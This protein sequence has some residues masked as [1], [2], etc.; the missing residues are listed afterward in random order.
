MEEVSSAAYSGADAAADEREAAAPEQAEAA[1]SYPAES[2]QEDRPAQDLPAQGVPDGLPDMDMLRSERARLEAEQERTSAERSRLVAEEQVRQIG[3]LD[4]EIKSLD[5]LLDMPEYGS[6]YELV[7]KGVSLV[8]AYKL[9]RYDKLMKRAAD[10]AARQTVRSIGSRRHLTALAGQ[11]GTGEY[12]SV[13]AEVAAEYRLAKPGI[14]DEEIR[15][16]YR[17]YQKYQR[18]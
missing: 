9:V 15:R 8:Q 12:V 10:A 1:A 11:P 4:G 13:P 3:E 16:K 2:G 7:K 5:D 17:K 18:Q 6:F 14:T